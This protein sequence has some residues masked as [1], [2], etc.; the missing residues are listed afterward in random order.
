[1]T[2]HGSPSLLRSGG[3]ETVAGDGRGAGDMQARLPRWLVRSIPSGGRKRR[4]EST[5]R[6]HGLHTV[7]EEAKCPNRCG[8]YGRGTATFLIM[9]P[10]CTRDCTFCGVGNTTVSAIDPTE[11]HR[12]AETVRDLGL[13]FVVVTSVT[14]D[15]LPDGGAAQFAQTIRLLKRQE[16]SPGVEVLV[17]D[18]KGDPEALRTVLEA[19]PDV[20]NHNVE[21][22]ARL[23]PQVRP[24]ADYRQSL[25]LLR[26]AATYSSSI[27]VKS[28]MMAGLGEEREEVSETLRDLHHAGCRIVT[29]GQYLRPSSTQRPVS[30]FVEPREFEEY[31]EWGRKIGFARVLSGPYVRSSYRAG[32]IFEEVRGPAPASS[33]NPPTGRGT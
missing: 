22:C 27:L 13:S 32:E 7:C 11:P 12:L 19:G 3:R 17:P 29:I 20:L 1:M 6:G 15:D 2:E 10:H 33:E 21:T 16:P 9:G 23:Y 31:A 5:L 14:R 26:R 8:C 28:G 18:F 25:E 24:S 4:V 30:R